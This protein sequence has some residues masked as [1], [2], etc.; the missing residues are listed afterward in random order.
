[1]DNLKKVLYVV[2]VLFISFFILYFCGVFDVPNTQKP[3]YPSVY[4]QGIDLLQFE[5]KTPMQQ[6]ATPNVTAFTPDFHLYS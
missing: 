6:A 1:M 3:E 2:I 5:L 4:W